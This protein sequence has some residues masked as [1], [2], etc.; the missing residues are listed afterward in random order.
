M[1][2]CMRRILFV[3]PDAAHRK[4]YE[5]VLK[6]EE[7]AWELVFVNN[8]YSAAE[9]NAI[10]PFDILVT[11]GNLP[12]MSGLELLEII[13]NSTPQTIRF[14]L[15]GENDQQAKFS[16]G[17]VQQVVTKPVKLPEFTAQVNRALALRS[18]IQNPAM[19]EL[20]GT[21]DSLPPMPRTY[22]QLITTLN[23][24]DSSISDVAT[25]VAQDVA[26]SAKILQ[27]VNSALFSLRSPVQNIL[28]A[29]SLLGTGTI[30]SMVFAQGLFKTFG[31]ENDIAF[32]EQLNQHSLQTA[33]GTAKILK[34]WKVGRDVI[35]SAMFCG[36]AHDL[37]KIVLRKYKPD[38]WKEITETILTSGLPDFEVERMALKVSHAELGAYLLG[39][40]G[41]PDAQVE[42]VAFHHEPSRS[43]NKEI[44]LLTAL[45]LAENMC[46]PHNQNQELDTDYL[47]E[48]HITEAVTSACDELMLQQQ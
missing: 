40:W 13:K 12:D 6:P 16:I 42:A 21:I 22:Q 14:L 3:E 1:A 11:A 33:L 39:I 28:Q 26:L 17:P 23:N 8:A 18:A 2:T 25:I 36:M 4:I 38:Y 37:G 45:H 46:D 35:D 48:P 20:A 47:S 9:A 24:P 29:I 5:S 10:E 7:N 32:F 41:F 34:S 30:S 27:I 43:S 15:A 31:D 19:L 44:G